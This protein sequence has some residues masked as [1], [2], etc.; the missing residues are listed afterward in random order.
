MSETSRYLMLARFIA[1][2]I[3]AQGQ[4]SGKNRGLGKHPA[5]YITFYGIG[6]SGR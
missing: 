4:H 3:V 1:S 5:P 6:T 2:F